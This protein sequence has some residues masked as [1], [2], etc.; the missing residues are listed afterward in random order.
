[1]TL[2][3]KNTARS[4]TPSTQNI[5]QIS[6]ELQTDI[7]LSVS[8]HP[9]TRSPYVPLLTSPTASST[10]TTV[11]VYDT[12]SSHHHPSTTQTYAGK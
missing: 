8:Q 10:D 9:V 5:P 6:G 7:Y 12:K 3:S 2:L 1:M 11:L 4:K